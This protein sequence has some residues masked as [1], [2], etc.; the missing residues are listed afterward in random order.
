MI[1]NIPG[2]IED[3]VCSTAARVARSHR[4]LVSKDDL[5]QEIRLWFITHPDRAKGWMDKDNL[6]EPLHVFK[7]IAYRRC[8]DYV[9]T[10]RAARTG[11]SRADHYLYSVGLIEEALPMVWDRQA[12]PVQEVS[13]EPRRKKAKPSAESDW[14]AIVVDVASA[15]ERLGEWDQ[16]LLEYRFRAPGHSLAE[17]GKHFEIS[18]PTASRRI[19]RAVHRLADFLGGVNPWR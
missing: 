13:E 5:A 3:I 18:V 2:H 14:P 11:G 17:V 1:D 6:V 12:R 15:F 4:H 16:E 19:S 7:A 8:Q 10:E 9:A